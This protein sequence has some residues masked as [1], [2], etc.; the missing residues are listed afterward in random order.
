MLFLSFALATLALNLAPGPD[1]TYVAARTLGHGRRAGVISAMGISAGCL[2][3][4]A[5]ATAGLAVLLRTVPQAYNALRI[6]GAAYLIYLGIGMLRA[7]GRIE[8][9]SDLSTATDGAIFRQGVITNVLNPKVAI[10]FLAFLPQFVDQTRGRVEL[11]TMGLGFYFITSGTIVNVSVAFV[12]SRV[13]RILSSVKARQ[14]IER[15]SGG[16]LLALGLR[17]AFTKAA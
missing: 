3:H 8:L 2:F 7:A 12:V 16:I 10:F 15:V 17:L 9:T 6:A 14:R 5:S 13:R 11:Q 1:M 4:V